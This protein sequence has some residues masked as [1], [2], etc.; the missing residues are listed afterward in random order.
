MIPFGPDSVEI[1]AGQA[2]LIP[3]WKGVI[4]Q[5][6]RMR[7]LTCPVTYAWTMRSLRGCS[8]SGSGLEPVCR[9]P[10]A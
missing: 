2:A 9:I 7:P 4:G 6:G 3:L 10:R 8:F 5:N 1:E